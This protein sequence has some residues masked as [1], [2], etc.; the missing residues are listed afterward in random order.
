MSTRPPITA[1]AVAA[2]LVALADRAAYLA[3]EAPEAGYGDGPPPALHYLVA[4]RR[5]LESAARILPE[6]SAVEDAPHAP[7]DPEL[8]TAL[9]PGA[10]EGP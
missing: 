9:E 10:A 8:S 7:T 1:E 3:G 4:A 5:C 2:R 6:P